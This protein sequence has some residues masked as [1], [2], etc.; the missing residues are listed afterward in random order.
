MLREQAIEWRAV[1]A[2]QAGKVVPVAVEA[3]IAMSFRNRDQLGRSQYRPDSWRIVLRHFI[4]PDK[5]FDFRAA[6]FLG[7][8]CEQPVLGAASALPLC[9][10]R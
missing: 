2:G 1:A 3:Q 10:H 8:S 4:D 7:H 9:K 5:Q 6:A